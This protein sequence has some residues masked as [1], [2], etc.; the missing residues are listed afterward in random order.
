VRRRRPRLVL[1]VGDDGV[2]QANSTMLGCWY[3]KPRLEGCAGALAT[4]DISLIFS[5]RIR[6]RQPKRSGW[7]S[8]ISRRRGHRVKLQRPWAADCLHLACISLPKPPLSSL[9]PLI[10]QSAIQRSEDRTSPTSNSAGISS[11]ETQGTLWG[12]SA[13]RAYIGS[14]ASD[15]GLRISL[16]PMTRTRLDPHGTPISV[17]PVIPDVSVP[18]GR[19]KAGH[20]WPV[21]LA[22]TIRIM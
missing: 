5:F 16:A 11:G 3:S 4:A 15:S 8:A 21:F 12:A 22:F 9:N 7:Y 13:H 14:S 6:R 18:G 19:P 1:G 2:D 10:A 20:S 17:T